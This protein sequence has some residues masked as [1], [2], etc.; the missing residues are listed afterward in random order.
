MTTENCRQQ[1]P[2][3]PKP[4]W[5][6]GSRTRALSQYLLGLQN[7]YYL[8]PGVSEH[9]K[10]AC[11]CPAKRPKLNTRTNTRSFWANEDS[12]LG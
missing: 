6:S 9:V 4:C 2:D 5:L 7:R 10:T 1:Q 8:G 12:V 11:T 3:P